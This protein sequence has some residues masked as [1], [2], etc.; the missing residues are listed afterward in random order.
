MICCLFI[1][2]LLAPLGLWI[3]PTTD[4]SNAACCAN[5]RAAA[6]VAVAGILTATACLL[7]LTLPQNAPFHHICKFIALPG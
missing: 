1:A 7:I 6:F 3:T 4:S 2:G 5:R